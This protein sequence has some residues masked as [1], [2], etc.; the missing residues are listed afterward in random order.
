MNS[1]TQR[2]ALFLTHYPLALKE[3]LFI[4]PL[5]AYLYQQSGSLKGWPT[6]SGVKAFALSFK[7]SDAAIRTSVSRANKE[8]VIAVVRHAAQ[9]RVVL[10]EELRQYAQ[11]FL[12]KPYENNC[13]SLLLFHFSTAEASQRNALKEM[14]NRYHY[15]MLT[16]N[17]Y[18]RYGGQ[19]E[20]FD[21]LLE[22]QGFAEHVYH[23][24]GLEQLP[25]RIV[26][27]ID[28][29][30][31]TEFWRLHLPEI[32]QD[33]E[34]FL[35][36]YPLDTEPGLL[37]YLY[38]RVAFHKHVLARA[39][40]LPASLFPA[41]EELQHAYRWLLEQGQRHHAKQVELFQDFFMG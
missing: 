27:E 20:A 24:H 21:R 33:F 16:Q 2:E 35:A 34:L 25:R 19:S 38:A 15:V 23:F 3:V 39:P 17:A 37:R 22:Q 8:G 5:F 40:H 12:N 36:Q 30:Y 7:H 10:G 11:F 6:L 41:V 4:P 26:N 18:L 31:P 29:L 28:D 14:L 32:V 9:K 1:M 13:F